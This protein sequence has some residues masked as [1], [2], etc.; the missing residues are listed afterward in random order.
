MSE[1]PLLE[2]Y[3]T[4]HEQSLKKRHVAK[5]NPQKWFKTIDRVYPD[6][7]TSPKLLIPDIKSQL[8]VVYD[9]GNY[10]PNNSIYYIC[11]K[12]WDLKALKAVL[13][14]GI[15][16]LFVQNYSTKVAGGHLRFQAQHLRRIPI[17]PWESI[18]F[19]TQTKLIKAGQDNDILLA[20]QLVIDLY[21]LSLKEQQVLG[22]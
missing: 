14:S 22:I 8:T 17:P 21:G 1:F 18:D 12:S 20:Q 6:R 13:L 15:G 19:K 4:T 16:L 5:V 7:A 9:E 11:S 10:H 3:L 2:G